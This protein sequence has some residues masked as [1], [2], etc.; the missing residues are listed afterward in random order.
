VKAL[1][2]RQPWAFAL[3]TGR[4]PIE[5]RTWDTT[6]RGQLAIHAAGTMT[7]PEWQR[8]VYGP[9][10]VGEPPAGE[11]ETL[12]LGSVL[13]VVELEGTHH[14]DECEQL[15]AGQMC[16]PWAMPDVFHWVIRPGLVCDPLPMKGRLQL[17]ET[18]DLL[19]MNARRV[20]AHP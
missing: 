5:N 6:H 8:A 12:H 11:E 10:W 18:G 20:E 7:I 2:V 19:L 3:V 14:A 1:T 15:G 9:H 13:G 16:S 4:K 17:W